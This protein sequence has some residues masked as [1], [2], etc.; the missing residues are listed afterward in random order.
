MSTMTWEVG[1]EA[2][3][4]GAGLSFLSYFVIDGWTKAGQVIEYALQWLRE[5]DQS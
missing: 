5:Y 4:I 1:L 2:I 3:A